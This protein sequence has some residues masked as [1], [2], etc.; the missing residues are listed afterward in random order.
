MTE[1]QRFT[2]DERLRRNAS[3]DP[4]TDTALT[5]PTGDM[6]DG[7]SEDSVRNSGQMTQSTDDLESR[8]MLS[9]ED[10]VNRKKPINQSSSAYIGGGADNGSNL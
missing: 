4:D 7:I 10:T 6:G 3:E 9:T 1:Q 8:E 2:T 5:P